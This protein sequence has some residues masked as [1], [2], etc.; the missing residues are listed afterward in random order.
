MGPSRTLIL[1]NGRRKTYEFPIGNK[2][3]RD[4]GET[5]ADISTIPERYRK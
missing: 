5:G 2:L 3:L 1:I 4:V